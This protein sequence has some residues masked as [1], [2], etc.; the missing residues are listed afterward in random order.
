MQLT[1][2]YQCVLQQLVQQF[3]QCSE[4]VALGVAGSLGRGNADQNSDIDLYVYTQGHITV[5]QR[6]AIADALGTVRR[7]L[8]LQFWDLGDQWIDAQTG[9]EVDVIYWDTQ[10]IQDQIQGVLQQHWVSMGYSTCFWHTVQHSAVMYDPCGWLAE[11][12][13]Q[14]RQPYPA[15]LRE[16]IVRKNLAVLKSVIPAYYSQIEKAL[17]RADWVSV[18][19][20]IAAFLASYFDV[21]FAL[22]EETHPGEKRLLVSAQ[23]LSLQP[24]NMVADIEQVLQQPYQADS[25][26]N[27]LSRLEAGLADLVSTHLGI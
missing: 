21:L 13:Q 14:C 9:I 23:Q 12:Q 16:G 25:L 26:L 10:W 24:D 20:R 11:L 1:D 6:C 22:N 7:D 19:H 18:N 5:A 2:N 15:A 3:S 8:D 4:V 27:A 17:K